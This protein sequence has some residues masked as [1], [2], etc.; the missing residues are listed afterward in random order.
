M[1]SKTMGPYYDHQVGRFEPPDPVKDREILLARARRARAQ[2]MAEVFGALWA[3]LRTSAKAVAGFVR[4][5]GV[6]AALK[7]PLGDAHHH[8]TARLTGGCN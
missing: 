6:G 4:H 8:R 1:R 2:A 5:A 7:P 3:G